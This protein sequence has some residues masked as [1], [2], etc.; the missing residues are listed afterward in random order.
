MMKTEVKK[1]KVTKFTAIENV[2]L[3][4][5]V[6]HFNH[7]NIDDYTTFRLLNA[8]DEIETYIKGKE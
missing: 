5:D 7:S 8:I 4:K 6:I 3:M 1:Y 2:N